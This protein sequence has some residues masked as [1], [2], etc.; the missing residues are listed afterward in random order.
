MEDFYEF[1]MDAYGYGPVT[2]IG[3]RLRSLCPFHEEEEP[4]FFLDLDKLYYRCYGC[5][6]NG[7]LLKLLRVV[8]NMNAVEAEQISQRFQINREIRATTT[9]EEKVWHR[10][11]FMSYL[12]EAMV[13]RG[14]EESFLLENSIGY[15]PFHYRTVFMVYSP[16]DRLV[17]HYYRTDNDSPIDAPR[18]FGYFNVHDKVYCPSR[19]WEG[20]SLLVEGPVDALGALSRLNEFDEYNSVCSIFGLG[21]AD[22]Q[23]EVFAKYFNKIGIMLD[24]DRAAKRELPDIHNK[25]VTAGI[26]DIEIIKYTGEDPGSLDFCDISY[27]KPWEIIWD[28]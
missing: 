8:F 4:S 12:P 24:N 23:A 1:L 20:N 19:V 11:P 27:C 18:Y 17:G 25:L 21:F 6:A 3:D 2:V 14:F 9:V 13:A 15:D 5:K 26:R 28:R 16:D 22:N 10:Q 7:P